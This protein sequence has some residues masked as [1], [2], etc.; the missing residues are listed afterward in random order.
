MNDEIN[1]ALR[2]ARTRGRFTLD[3]FTGE[4]LDAP[5]DIEPPDQPDPAPRKGDWDGGIRGSAPPPPPPP[6]MNDV[7]RKSVQRQKGI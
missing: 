2:E 4:L 5:P 1:A 7:I 6:D 3:A